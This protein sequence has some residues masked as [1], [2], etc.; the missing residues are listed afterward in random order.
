MFHSALRPRVHSAPAA[1]RHCRQAD[2]AAPAPTAAAIHTC[3]SPTLKPNTQRGC[4]LRPLITLAE[5]G[6]MSAAAAA[7]AAN[8]HNPAAP[9]Y[10]NHSL[11][12]KAPRCTA[13][14]TQAAHS[15]H[16]R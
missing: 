10:D 16:T 2:T 12:A 14:H 15:I 8:C 6:S 7:A 9:L 11:R 1:L 13:A 3:A 4:L 5:G